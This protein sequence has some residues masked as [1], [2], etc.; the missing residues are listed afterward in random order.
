[1]NAVTSDFDRHTAEVTTP[2]GATYRSTAPPLLALRRAL[3]ISEVEVA[4]TVA[5]DDLH[6]A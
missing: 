1:M 2:T 3:D 5:L 6:A 4:I